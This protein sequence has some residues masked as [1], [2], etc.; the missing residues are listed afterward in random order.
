MKI[1][2]SILGAALILVSGILWFRALSQPAIS[3]SLPFGAVQDPEFGLVIPSHILI[4]FK[5]DASA[6]QIS[7]TI[8]LLRGSVITTSPPIR[9]WEVALPWSKTDDDLH[10]AISL[11]AS[12]SFV[13]SA[14]PD[15]L[16]TIPALGD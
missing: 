8:A 14:T 3:S 1:L 13:E 2:L 6:A 12:S 5:P 9:M 10:H 11:L 7:S 15:Q 4:F 16:S